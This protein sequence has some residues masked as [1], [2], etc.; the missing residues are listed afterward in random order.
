MFDSFHAEK[1]QMIHCCYLEMT[2]E[3]LDIAILAKLSCGMH[4]SQMTSR[5]RKKEQTVRN[6]QIMPSAQI[7]C[8]HGM[9][10][11]RDTFKYLHSIGQGKLNRL[12]K[13]YKQ[14]SHGQNSWKPQAATFQ[15]TSLGDYQVFEEVISSSS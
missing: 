4:L 10:I 15:C 6:A 7:F 12:I 5:F 2:R 13:H 3:E 1:L 11:Y 9:K 14:H 8:H